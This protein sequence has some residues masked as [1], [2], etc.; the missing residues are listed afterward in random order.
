MTPSPV[1]RAAHATTLT[2]LHPLR[3]R[4]LGA[5][6]TLYRGYQTLQEVLDDEGYATAAFTGTE[7][8]RGESAIGQGF[9]VHDDGAPRWSRLLLARYLGW[10]WT[11]APSGSRVDSWV[12]W[13]EQHEQQP[14]MAWIELADLDAWERTDGLSTEAYN[15]AVGQ[16][17]SALGLSLIHI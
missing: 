9:R 2:G 6:D 14:W 10:N 11:V 4:V 5:S 3:H 13:L 7:A 1:T 12:A 16:V 8:A 15:D 17:D